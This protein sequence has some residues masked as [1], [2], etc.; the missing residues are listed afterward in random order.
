MQPYKVQL[1]LRRIRDGL[2][3][4]GQVKADNLIWNHREFKGD[5]GVNF[6]SSLPH[7]IGKV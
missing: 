1:E 6:T 5:T 2:R 3:L 7:I 4:R